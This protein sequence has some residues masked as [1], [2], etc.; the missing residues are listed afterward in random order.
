MTSFYRS[1]CEFKMFIFRNRASL[2]FFNFCHAI[3]S[4][5]LWISA[6]LV[7]NFNFGL[8]LSFLLRLVLSLQSSLSLEGAISL[9]SRRVNYRFQPP[10]PYLI[11]Y[12][13][14]ANNST[15]KYSCTQLNVLKSAKKNHVKFSFLK[16]LNIKVSYSIFKL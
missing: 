9:N 4:F 15:L 13:I 6:R 14:V 2:T 7:L 8:S 11:F 5:F 12:L 3:Y 1:N 10:R 16:N